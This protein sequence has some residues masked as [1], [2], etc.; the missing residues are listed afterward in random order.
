[1]ANVGQKVQTKFGD[2][3]D[4]P[5]CLSAFTEPRILP[6][7]HTFCFECLKRTLEVTQKKKGNKIPCPLCRSEFS[8]EHFLG[9]K[10]ILQMD[11]ASIICDM[12]NAGYG[13]KPGH[14]Q[15]A[16]MHCIECQNNYCDKCVEVHKSQ[17]LSR[18]HKVIKIESDAKSEIN[19]ITEYCS[20]HR[21]KALDYYCFDCKKIVCVSCF[22][23]S[24]KLHDCK[25][26]TTLDEEFRQTIQ[27]NAAKVFIYVN[28][29]LFLR[30]NEEFRKAA[31]YRNR[32]LKI[33][34]KV[35]FVTK[36]V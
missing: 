25:D 15:E 20:K 36:T 2:M 19:P 26:V 33:K 3:I 18:N 8:V 24:H 10:C 4:C 9:L 23:E 17:K 34:H 14:I 28:E 5:I 6:C 12:C 21:K 32:I 31:F 30:E 27:P 35:Q 7:I 16:T 29:M 13:D 1:M 11:V 22:D